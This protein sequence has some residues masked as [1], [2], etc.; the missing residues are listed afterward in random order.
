VRTLAVLAA[1][2]LTGYVLGRTCLTTPTGPCRTVVA[3]LEQ[4]WPWLVL[5]PLVATATYWTVRAF[6]RGQ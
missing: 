1:A 3:A 4:P 6:R 2:A 5:P